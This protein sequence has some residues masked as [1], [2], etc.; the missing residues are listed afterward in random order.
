MVPNAIL[1]ST[2][3]AWNGLNNVKSLV[4]L[5][6]DRDLCAMQAKP[7]ISVQPKRIYLS[8]KSDI[9]HKLMNEDQVEDEF[10]KH[11]FMII[12]PRSLPYDELA[13]LVANSDFLAGPSG[14]AM[15]RSIMCKPGAT[16]IRLTY[17]GFPNYA[18]HKLI[19]L[20][21]A[22]KSYEYLESKELTLRDKTHS[23]KSFSHVISWQINIDNLRYF[24]GEIF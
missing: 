22:Q 19:S 3:F 24:L 16:I 9:A 13:H 18:T 5:F 12:E 1:I 20:S 23:D 14:S 4:S 15:V 6:S 21:G 7:Q 8:R 17:E 11:N 10:R 2:T